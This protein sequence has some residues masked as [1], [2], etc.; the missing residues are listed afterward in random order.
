LTHTNSCP[1][2]G[3]GVAVAGPPVAGAAAG[4]ALTELLGLNKLPRR[5]LPGDADA[6][7]LVAGRAAASVF[8]F[9]RVLPGAGVAAAGPPVAGAAAGDALTDL[10]GL[11]KLRR[12]N[13]P[14][15]GDVVGLGAGLAAAS[16]FGFLR[17][18]FTFGN[19]AGDSAV[20]GEAA[21]SAGEA[22]AS[23]FLCWRCFLAG[24]GDSAGNSAGA[25]N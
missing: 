12:L 8:G 14:R 16:V 1:P 20:A 10:L 6:V 25:T 19:A 3:A 5:N 4:D 17:V 9:S 21:V 18:R 23:A 11:N 2:P 7:G 24:E 13:L 15:D 22:V